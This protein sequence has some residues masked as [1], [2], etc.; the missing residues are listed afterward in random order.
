MGRESESKDEVL[1]EISQ[2]SSTSY[3]PTA[4]GGTVTRAFVDEMAKFFG[5]AATGDKTSVL[6]ACLE[7]VGLPWRSQFDSR[8]SRSGGGGTI[9]WYGLIAIRNA[10]IDSLSRATSEDDSGYLLTSF[11]SELSKYLKVS[12]FYNH[13]GK[14]EPGEIDAD[15]LSDGF[16]RHN[17]SQNLLADLLE[18]NGASVFMSHGGLPKFDLL[19]TSERGSFVC[20][21]KSVTSENEETQLRKAIG[22]VLRY[23]CQ[24]ETAGIP[25]S[26]V[27]LTDVLVKDLSWHKVFADNNIHL[28]SGPYFEGLEALI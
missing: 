26:A 19:W 14:F 9:T 11:G 4:R 20:E 7:S 13:E 24:L 8:G 27:V 25:C 5:V 28:I 17:K 1:L 6:A 15:L 21:V 18:K 3:Y 2:L 23:Q 10:V 12:E 16:E 22:Q